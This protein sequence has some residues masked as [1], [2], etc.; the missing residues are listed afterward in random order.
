MYQAVFVSE[1]L[2]GAVEEGADGVGE[3]SVAVFFSDP[4]EEDEDS[5]DPASVMPFRA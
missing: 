2:E 1:P 5:E 3:L 4:S